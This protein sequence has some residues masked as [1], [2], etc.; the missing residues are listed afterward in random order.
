MVQDPSVKLGMSKIQIAKYLR[1][2]MLGIPITSFRMYKVC[3]PVHSFSGYENNYNN[4]Y[5]V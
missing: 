4:S 2:C 1:S 3:L 5:T